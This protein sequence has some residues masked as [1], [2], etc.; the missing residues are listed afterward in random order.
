ME[1]RENDGG[2]N[3]PTARCR[4]VALQVHPRRNSVSS[5]SVHYHFFLIPDSLKFISVLS[6]GPLNS[7]SPPLKRIPCRR[8]FRL[9]LRGNPQ[10]TPPELDLVAFTLQATRNEPCLPPPICAIAKA[11]DRPLPILRNSN[12]APVTPHLRAHPQAHPFE[13]KTMRSYSS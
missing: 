4:S 13:T 3:K 6:N 9:H 5:S 11:P 10:H 7:V 1:E 2:V 8:G 12:F